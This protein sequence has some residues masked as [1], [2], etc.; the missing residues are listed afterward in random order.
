MNADVRNH[1]SSLLETSSAEVLE[2][3]LVTLCCSELGTER[4]EAGWPR[5]LL[6]CSV[7]DKWAKTDEDRRAASTAIERLENAEELRNKRRLSPAEGAKQCLA[8]KRLVERKAQIVPVCG[9]GDCL[10][11]SVVHVLFNRRDLPEELE[12]D[13]N[14]RL[15]KLCTKVCYN[16]APEAERRRYTEEDWNTTFMSEE[17]MSQHGTYADFAE[18]YKLAVL[19]SLFCSFNATCHGNIRDTSDTDRELWVVRHDGNVSFENGVVKPGTNYMFCHGSFQQKEGTQKS[20]HDR[21]IRVFY[22]SYVCHST[23]TALLL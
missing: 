10:F 2:E 23:T 15:R 16:D 18:V 13:L 21:E 17:G 22:D 1:I 12:N 3:G 19:L 9:D 6:A 11:R 8:F 14:A 20:P 4:P 5:V 7:L